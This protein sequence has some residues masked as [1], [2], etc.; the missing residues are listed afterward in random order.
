LTI[1]ASEQGA[2]LDTATVTQT[3]A[4]TAYERGAGLDSAVVFKTV[5]APVPATAAPLASPAFILSQ[6]PRMHAQNLLT[7]QWW[8]RDVQGITAPTITW[9]LNAP[10]TF[11]CTLAPPRADMLDATGNPLLVEW[12]DAIYLEESGQIKFGGILTSSTMA[13]PAWTLT[14]ME[15]SCYP[16]GMIYEGPNFSTTEI[17][18]LDA[19]RY[20]WGWLQSQPGGDLQMQLGT[21]KAGVMLGAQTAAGATTALSRPAAAGQP[22]IYVPA[23][24]AATLTGGEGITISG[25]PYT[26]G[27]VWATPNGVADGHMTLTGNLGEPH[28]AG[29][30]VAQVTPVTAVLDK[31]AKAGQRVIWMDSTRAGAFT[32]GETISVGG[33]HY[34]VEAI[35][36][37]SKGLPDGSLTVNV[38]LLATY[39]IGT[40]VTQVQAITPFSLYWYNSVDCGQELTSIQQEAVFDF[41][42]LHTWNSDRT[43]VIHQLVFGVPRLGVRQMGLRFAEGENITQA[44]AI[45]RDGTLYASEVIGLGAGTG[46]AEVRA[47]AS[48][49]STGRLRRNAVY[50]DQTVQTTARMAVKANRQ[51]QAMQNIDM[52]TSVTIK[53]HPSAPFGSFGPGDDIPVTLCSGWR[54]AVIW[55][56]ITS[57]QQNPQE[58]T[59]VLALA[60]SDSYTYQQETGMAGSL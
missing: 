28:V 13:G 45:T 26:L 59:M 7:G 27:Q 29:E 32:T 56:R 48:N 44:A 34:A 8:H 55:S 12:R 22:Q 21:Q 3:T 38:N 42:E 58:D 9:T 14:A 23:A 37:D 46:S 4:V 47:T 40:R 16:A 57:M 39:P 19:V 24:G 54:N 49:A 11:S 31:E 50:T 41:R 35:G 43:G 33:T 53:N 20:I 6:M 15:F 52:V 51:L 60:R 5:A 30:P 25:I 17:D 10:G 1:N 36:A 2:A 18:A